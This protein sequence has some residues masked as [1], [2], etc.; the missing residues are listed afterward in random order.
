M[1]ESSET[2][3]TITPSAKQVVFLFMAATAGAV[4]VFIF[5]VVVG[6]GGGEPLVQANK[7]LI[8]DFNKNFSRLL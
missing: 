6:R 8:Q 5:G 3:K 4:I 7:I 2:S 1:T